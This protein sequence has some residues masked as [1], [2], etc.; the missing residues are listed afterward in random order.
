MLL[1]GAFEYLC[2][3][4]QEKAFGTVSWEY[5]HTP[6]NIGG[7]T[8]LLYAFFWGVLGL[9]WVKNLYPLLL[10]LIEK[11]P[12]KPGVVLTWVLCVFMA[13]NMG[14]SA[15]AS[16]RQADRRQGIPA[17]NAISRFLDEQYPD[18]F[19]EKIY[20]NAMPAD[21]IPAPGEEDAGA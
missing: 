5:S 14:V 20:P 2:S 7:R 10:R 12:R 6:F 8:N 16:A 1:G 21:D 11:I 18:E 9:I 4:L 17:Q 13:L 19:L 15:L 3:L